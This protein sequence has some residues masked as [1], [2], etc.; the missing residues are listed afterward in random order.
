MTC[1]S[2]AARVQ[3]A[4]SRV[5]GVESAFV[6]Y[7][8]GQAVVTLDGSA[9]QTDLVAAVERA[10]YGMEPVA[11]EGGWGRDDDE[12]AL[13]VRK[14]LVV[15]AVLTIPLVLL[16]F[17]PRLGEMLGLSHAGMAWLGV[18][19]ATPVQFWGG[20]QF[21]R[22]AAGRLRRLQTNMDT[23]IAVGSLSAYGYSVWS[24][25]AGRHTVYFET[26]AAIV[27]LILLGKY[28][29]ARAIGRTS[30]AVARLVELGAKQA[31][32]L[33]DGREVTVP[34]ERVVPGDLLVIRPGE[35]VPVDGRVVAGASAVNESMLTGEPVPVDKAPGD[36]VF[37]G[38]LNQQGRLEVVAD[39]VGAGTALA[40]IVELVKQAQGS[41]APVQKL[42]DRVAS[43][44][45]PVVLA[46]AGATFAGWYLATGSAE[47]ALLPSI[48]VLIIA[49]PCAMGLATPTAIMAGSG[50]GAEMGVLI[51]GGEVFERSG[52]LDAVV[53]D[54]TG[55]L[56]EGRMTVTD[57]VTAS[58]QIA[59][60]EVLAKA[61]SVEAGS[62]HPIGKAVVA[63]AVERGI[64]LSPVTGFQSAAGF[65][66]HGEVDG[67]VVIVGKAPLLQERGLVRSEE[68]KQEARRLQE[69]GKTV[70][71]VGWDGRAQGVVALSDRLRPGAR[72]AVAA[73][74][75][76]GIQVAMITGDNPVVAG[77]IGREVG[78]DHVIAGV[79][80]GGKA[81]EI[82]RM[83]SEGKMVA[84]VGDGINDAPALTQADLGVAIGTGAD[85]AIEASDIT[86]VSADPG[87]IPAALELARKTLRV[88]RQNLF[89]AFAYNVAA[90]PLAAFG[91][92]SPA[93][94]AGA[95]ALSSV[96][97]VANAL[98]L[99][100]FGARRRGEV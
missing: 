61:A 91:R 64:P 49:C 12:Q 17:V 35:K 70:V 82:R 83:Q 68:L 21:L 43:I 71:A 67:R 88:I 51:R 33:V 23:L 18:M 37:G 54:K 3:K 24:L 98:R 78:I 95:M 14:R 96:S 47:Q 22:S 94:A 60:S 75:K 2:C 44:F 10:G 19:L 69:E 73:L 79:L 80:P 90:I 100:T 5:P 31:T 93:I 28:F 42:A 56:T 39:R 53:L 9:E 40:Q 84:M 89:W 72:E 50:R 81:D 1:A 48:A 85:V 27:T 59:D 30:S 34:V 74:R 8:G 63:A 52:R 20:W 7:A 57:I 92:L 15:S 58:P 29:E 62:E 38:T 32:V 46:I 66:V 6:N 25:L 41:K 86:L 36:P 87:R 55:T 4:L 16:H 26:S 45:V 99:R 13:R 76:A 65:G 11:A 97:V 77:V